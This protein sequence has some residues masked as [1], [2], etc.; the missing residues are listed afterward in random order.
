MT[1]RGRPRE[2]DV[3]KALDRAIAVFSERGFHGTSIENLVQAT[4]LTAGSLYKAFKDKR[5]IFLAAF[6]RY[7]AVRGEAL[8]AILEGHSVDKYVTGLA[9]LEAALAFYAAASHGP[10]GRQGC[11][12][13]GTAVELATFDDEVARIVEGAMAQNEALLCSLI[14]QGQADGSIPAGVDPDA[15]GRTMLCLTQGLRVVGKTGRGLDDMKAVVEQ[16]LKIVG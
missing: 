3:D 4:G 13:V 16:A 7:R 8:A 2:F 12:V 15:A 10:S 5:G 9:R 1:T 14:R 11:L 6:A